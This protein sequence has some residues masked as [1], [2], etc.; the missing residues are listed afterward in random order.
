MSQF[1][2]FDIPEEV[3]SELRMLASEAN[4]L[5]TRVSSSLPVE[6][7]RDQVLSFADNVD[8]TLTWLI[9][10]EGPGPAEF[11][12]TPYKRPS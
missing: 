4:S 9:S 2:P 1:P 5:H 11:D 6:D 12:M 7:S 8:N 3:R 10:G